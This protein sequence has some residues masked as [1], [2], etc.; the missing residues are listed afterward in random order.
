MTPPS[1]IS[2]APRAASRGRKPGPA[3]TPVPATEETKAQQL[4]RARQMLRD[5]TREAEE[6]LVSAMRTSARFSI[7]HG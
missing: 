2:P 5:L 3:P 1:V 7:D 4:A 6:T